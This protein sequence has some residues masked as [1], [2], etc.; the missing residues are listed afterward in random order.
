MPDAIVVEDVTLTRFAH[1]EAVHF[2]FV[3]VGY[4]DLATV[5]PAAAQ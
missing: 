3:V 5:S 1:R 2:L 4:D